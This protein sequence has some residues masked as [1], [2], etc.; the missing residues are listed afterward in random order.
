MPNCHSPLRTLPCAP[1]PGVMK[2][3]GAHPWANAGRDASNTNSAKNA[4]FIAY[5]FDPIAIAFPANFPLTRPAGSGPP[6]NEMRNWSPDFPRRTV[7]APTMTGVLDAIVLLNVTKK[8]PL[9]GS[10]ITWWRHV[11]VMTGAP[12]RDDSGSGVVRSPCGLTV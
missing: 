6:N 10:E 8:W 4:R 12:S 11:E 5:F 7:S 2:R 3:T 9:L 1:G